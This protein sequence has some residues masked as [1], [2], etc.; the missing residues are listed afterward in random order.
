MNVCPHI[1]FSPSIGSQC[2]QT[3]ISGVRFNKALTHVVRRSSF[4][5]SEVMT[6]SF[7]TSWDTLNFRFVTSSSCC[8]NTN[9]MGQTGTTCRWCTLLAVTATAQSFSNELCSSHDYTHCVMCSYRSFTDWLKTEPGLFYSWISL[10]FRPTLALVHP[11]FQELFQSMPESELL[12]CDAASATSEA[13]VDLKHVDRCL[14]PPIPDDGLLRSPL[15]KVEIHS[16]IS[17][18]LPGCSMS[19]VTKGFDS[20]TLR[21]A[22]GNSKH[23]WVTSEAERMKIAERTFLEQVNWACE[24]NDQLRV[25]LWRARFHLTWSDVSSNQN[26]REQINHTFVSNLLFK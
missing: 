18:R 21:K 6:T 13:S 24:Q 26:T 11:Y 4:A 23:Y 7:K 14:Q 3:N 16:D 20:I 8:P 25:N 22:K 9:I 17:A 5:L 15:Q 19:L 12:T 2:S 1:L 10:T